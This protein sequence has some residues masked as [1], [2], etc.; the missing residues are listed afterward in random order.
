MRFGNFLFLSPSSSSSSGGGGK[1]LQ[2]AG[3][4]P[5]NWRLYIARATKRALFL[6]VLIGITVVAASVLLQPGQVYTDYPAWRNVTMLQ[7]LKMH[8]APRPSQVNRK[9]VCP[10]PLLKPAVA[11]GQMD[12]SK[13]SFYDKI[14]DKFKNL[15]PEEQ[16]KTAFAPS[17]TNEQKVCI[18]HLVMHGSA[19]G[20]WRFHGIT[21]W[22]DDIDIGI[23]AADWAGIKQALSCIEGFSLITTSNTKWYFYR[24]NGTFIRGDESTKRWPFLD[25][26]LY[27]H[28]SSYV[29]GLNYVHL[30][31][32][33]FR[34]EDMFPPQMVQFDGLMVPVAAHLRTI[35]EHQF[36]DPTVC[37]SQHLN[38]R[39]GTMLGV[40]KV[41]C[42]KLADIYTMYFTDN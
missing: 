5:T 31:K 41:P 6:M 28:D 22:D 34:I 4:V 12:T 27:S 25:L 20:A 17:L 11:L 39:N 14:S 36:V 9:I 32:F 37:V 19:L 38:H 3:N 33:T 29:F 8:L 18:G 26:F 40:L 10:S 35:L 21:P 1:D 24:N 13:I 42:D 30:R 15:D 16:W 7:I 23:D 2:S